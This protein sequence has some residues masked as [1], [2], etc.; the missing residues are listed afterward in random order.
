MSDVLEFKPRIK[1]MGHKLSIVFYV[2]GMKFQGDTLEKA[3]LGGSETAG[4]YM[5]REMAR[6]GHDV[7]VFSNTDSPGKYDGVNY[8]PIE[9]FTQYMLFTATDV[10]IAQRVPQ[11]FGVQMKSKLNILWQ[12]DIG[13]K[14]NA[15]NFRCS[16]WN[17]DEV[18]GVSRFHVDQMREV[19]GAPEKTFWATRNGVDRVEDLMLLERAKKRLIYT[20]RPERGMDTLIFDIMPKLW[21]I[22]PDIELRLAGYDNVVAE[23]KPFYDSI[24]A[25]IAEH[26]TAGRKI[27]WLGALTKR[28]LY[29]E[30]QQATAY[31]Y[32]TNFEEVSC[33]TA[34]ECM[35]NGLPFIGTKLAALPE[36]L[37]MGGQCATLIEGDAHSP[38][39]QERFVAAVMEHLTKFAEREENCAE[40]GRKAAALLL[41][42]DL[43]ADWETHLYELFAQRTANKETLAQHFYRNEDIVALKA[44]NIPAWNERVEKEYPLF[45]DPSAYAALYQVYG[46]NFR[47]QVEAG[48]LKVQINEYLRIKTAI[49]LM[50]NPATILDYGCA[51]GNEAIQF[52]NAFEDCKVTAV[53]ISHDEMEVGKTLAFTTCKKPE[54]IEW[55]QASAPEE[56]G[57]Q[58]NVVFAGE[59]LEHTPDPTAFVNAL[60]ARCIDGGQ[61]I[62]TVPLG[63]WG[64]VDT[65]CEQRGHVW[66]FER[67]DIKDLFSGKKDFRVQVVSGM[68][69]E[70]NSETLGWYVVSYTKSGAATGVVDLTRKC[71]I[72]APRQTLSTCMIIGG[73]QEGHL[74]KCMESIYGISDEIIICD[75][76]MSPYSREV[77]DKYIDKVKIISGAP[78]PLQVGFDEARNFGLSVATK[79]WILWVDSDEELLRPAQVLKYLRANCFEGYSIK[80]HHFSAQ[81]PNAFNPDLPTRLFRNN[82]GIK[83][84]GVIHEHPET[85]LNA[86]IGESTILSD[87]DIAHSGYLTEEVRRKRFERNYGL[88][89]RDREKYPDR[90]LGKFLMMRDWVHKARY[91][92]ERTMG[93]ST[94]EVIELCRQVVKCY[95]DEFLGKPTMMSTDGLSFY[96]EALS[97]L[98]QGLEYTFNIAAAPA[99]AHFNG[100]DITAR[101]ATKDDFMKYFDARVKANVV[102]YEG[103]YL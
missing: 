14:R 42:K 68:V 25:K 56:I 49:S 10:L 98:G 30:Y 41:W 3:S 40:A 31:V 28:Q 37:S 27:T 54:N 100:D 89:L 91:I 74:H 24:F 17:I 35:A 64:D 77:L 59:I 6:R 55:R 12:H 2:N 79:D 82:R 7:I 62:F 94:P 66:S 87:V 34:M 15:Q 22:D 88:M 5:A 101:F 80:Q 26:K 38:E 93:H 71:A 99:G 67:S 1:G 9:N 8:M 75:T 73:K 102:Q 58:F 51:I 53:N 61:M 18:W 65:V 76:G 69:N 47:E 96:S 92:R 13:L 46:K 86:G 45:I 43:A 85:A 16:L 44:L 21:V 90:V 4:L 84:F 52:V 95:Q 39:Y 50:K 97:I 36:T 20:A 32:P 33:I 11:V 83:F 70:K 48:K 57:G 72:Q 78:N 63:P 60:E 29:D 19:Y 23:M 103:R 81:P